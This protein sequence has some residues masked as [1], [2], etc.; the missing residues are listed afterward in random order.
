[1]DINKIASKYNMKV[2]NDQEIVQLILNGL[3]KRDGH[4][5]CL[6]I[7]N[8]DSLCPCKSMREKQ[9]CKCKLYI[10]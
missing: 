4:C 8:E 1:M 9:I 3:E 5:P 10:K 7:K 6:V 2:N